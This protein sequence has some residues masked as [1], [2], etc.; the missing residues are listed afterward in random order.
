MSHI[1]PN[2]VSYIGDEPMHVHIH[3]RSDHSS[4]RRLLRERVSLAAQKAVMDSYVGAGLVSRCIEYTVSN[5]NMRVP[6]EDAEVLMRYDVC[7]GHR[8]TASLRFALCGWDHT[9]CA[10]FSAGLTAH[11]KTINQDHH[12]LLFMESLMDAGMIQDINRW[13]SECASA[14]QH[15]DTMTDAFFAG[16]PDHLHDK[17]EVKEWRAAYPEFKTRIFISKK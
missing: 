5:I 9:L 8:R 3:N 12:H 10:A 15:A 17:S 1:I 6:P 13:T 16:R 11:L 2:L 4:M 14:R 7:V